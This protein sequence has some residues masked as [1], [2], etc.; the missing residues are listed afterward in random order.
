MEAKDE[1]EVIIEAEVEGELVK[2]WTKLPLNATSAI[3]LGTFNMSAQLGRRR[4]IMLRWMSTKK[5]F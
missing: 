1:A 5:F 2:L 3:S 4:P